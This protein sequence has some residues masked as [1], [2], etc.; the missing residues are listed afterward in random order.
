MASASYSSRKS[1]LLWGFLGLLFTISA[2]YRVMDISERVGELGH[3]REFV[4]DPFDVDL[5]RY[6][7][8]SVE[9]EAA[10]AGLKSGDRLTR[11][12][13]QRLHYSGTDL[14]VPLR[15]AR[16]GDRLTV[17]ASRL[18]GGQSSTFS[19]SIVLQPLRPGP[20]STLDVTQFAVLNV[21]MPII[22]TLLGFWVAAV[23]VRDG[24]AWL[25]LLLLLSVAELAGGNYHFLY[26]RQDFFQPIAAAYQPVLANFWPTAMLLFAIYFPE[27]LP[28]DQRAP[29]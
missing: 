27:R 25:L 8:V 17:E 21:L 4:R 18:T 5:P 15:A 14:W 1:Y 13:N 6:D 19:A 24:R 29:G 28:L 7:L 26:G 16:A 11:I 3:G 23:R 9:Q 12:N 2:T 20:P 22:C 10:R